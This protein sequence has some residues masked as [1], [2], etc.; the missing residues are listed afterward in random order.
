MSKYAEIPSVE[1]HPEIGRIRARLDSIRADADKLKQERSAVET[2]IGLKPGQTLEDA[3]AAAIYA[4]QDPDTLSAGV[5]KIEAIDRRIK[6]TQKAAALIESDAI[7]VRDRVRKELAHEVTERIWRPAVREAVGKWLKLAVELEKF[8]RLVVLIQ[9]SGLNANVYTPF[10]A[11]APLSRYAEEALR[12]YVLD[13]LR[14]G[15]LD[16]GQVDAAFPDLI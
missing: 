15:L 13:L 1:S 9:D 6:A 7:A 5:A 16:R 8:R 12:S 14:D 2:E 3:E 10:N 4:G 11:N